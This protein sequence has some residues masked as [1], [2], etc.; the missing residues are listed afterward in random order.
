MILISHRG[1]ITGP[2]HNLENH[3]SYLEKALQFGFNVE[4]DVWYVDNKLYLGHDK[5]Q[6][7]VDLKYLQNDKFW[8]HCKNIGALNFLL[9]NKIHCFFHQKDDVTLTS[10]GYMWTFPNKKLIE[11]AICVMPEYGYDGNLIMCAGICSDNI[12]DWRHMAQIEKVLSKTPDKRENKTTTSL[13][14]KRDLI[15]FFTKNNKKNGTIVELGTDHGYTTKVLSYLFKNVIT[16]D[17][18]PQR[19]N[20]AKVYNQSRE[21]IAYFT[22]DTYS[23]SWWKVSNK[24]DAIFVD[25]T[26][27][28]ENVILDIKNCLKIDNEC[29]I[30]FDDYGL[31]NGVK[32]AVDEYIENKKL[33]FVKHIGESVGSDCRPGKLLQ[34]WEGIICRVKKD[35][36]VA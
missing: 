13:Q 11:N 26:H 33:S 6:Y 2:N 32:K 27:A 10:K 17:I 16:F 22:E 23:Y 15:D 34:D 24:I 1:N 14:F 25:V 30:I 31:F 8:C 19:T 12:K 21:N 28:Y 4:I 18:E 7:A 9:K 5:P 29:Y 36:Q 35:K 20:I 3:P